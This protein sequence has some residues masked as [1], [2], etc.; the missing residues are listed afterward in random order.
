MVEFRRAPA[1][2]GHHLVGA[3][4]CLNGFGRPGQNLPYPVKPL[5]DREV[6]FI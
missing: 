2:M 4:A 6:H 3:G 1:R 5:H